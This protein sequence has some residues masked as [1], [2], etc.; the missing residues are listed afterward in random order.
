MWRYM[1]DGFGVVTSNQKLRDSDDTGRCAQVL[2]R[3]V[4]LVY[5]YK[6]SKVHD[7][8][9]IRFVTA[10]FMVGWIERRL[11][12]WMYFITAIVRSCVKLAKLKFLFEYVKNS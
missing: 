11:L 4:I 7:F 1:C 12:D 8:H 3:I 2:W 10:L 9:I 6:V 5:G